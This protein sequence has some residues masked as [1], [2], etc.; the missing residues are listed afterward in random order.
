[1]NHE[2]LFKV[3]CIKINGGYERFHNGRKNSFKVKIFSRD[4]IENAGM[5]RPLSITDGP[6]PT[7][8]NQ[9][10]PLLLPNT[11]KDILSL[12]FYDVSFFNPSGTCNQPDF[13]NLLFF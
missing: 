3:H 7:G 8:E 12:H 6:H 4:S 11:H 2:I 10:A 5:A 1:M 13:L 9:T